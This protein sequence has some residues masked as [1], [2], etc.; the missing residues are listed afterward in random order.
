MCRCL[1]SYIPFVLELIYRT[2]CFVPR[3]TFIIILTFDG[4]WN[5]FSVAAKESFNIK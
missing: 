3:F 5:Q 2:I 1:M 4:M